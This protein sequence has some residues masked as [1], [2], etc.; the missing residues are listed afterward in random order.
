MTGGHYYTYNALSH[1]IYGIFMPFLAYRDILRPA[2][3]NY[4]P[5]YQKGHKYTLDKLPQGIICFLLCLECQK[6]IYL[7]HIFLKLC[8]WGGYSQIKAI[9]LVAIG[10]NGSN[11]QGFFYQKLDQGKWRFPISSYTRGIIEFNFRSQLSNI[12]I[13]SLWDTLV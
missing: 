7:Y 9:P 1:F 10:G 8:E 11:D 5:I 4:I 2:G 13:N 12:C 3:P 6:Y